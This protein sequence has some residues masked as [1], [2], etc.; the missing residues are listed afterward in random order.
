MNLALFLRT[1]EVGEDSAILLNILIFP[2]ISEEKAGVTSKN[3]T[4]NSKPL[5][6]LPVRLK[7]CECWLPEEPEPCNP[8]TCL[9]GKGDC[10]PPGSSIP[11]NL[12]C[13]SWCNE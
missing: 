3:Y 1:V 11:D 5:I 10:Y 7:T 6:V 2:L 4:T 8:P 9:D 13:D 12:I